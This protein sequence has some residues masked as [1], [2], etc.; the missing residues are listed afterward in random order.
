M[1]KGVIAFLGLIAALTVIVP[2]W[3]AAP[4]DEVPITC[5]VVDTEVAARLLGAPLGPP[6][7][8]NI[9]VCTG[10]CPSL[11]S[12]PRCSFPVA[13][14]TG[15]GQAKAL[16]VGLDLRPFEP[17]DWAA[18]SYMVGK[19]K[20]SSDVRYIRWDGH[21]TVWDFD[22]QENWAVY[23]VFVGPRRHLCATLQI[24]LD[25]IRDDAVALRTAQTLAQ[26]ALVR[27]SQATPEEMILPDWVKRPEIDRQALCVN[28]IG[29]G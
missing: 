20:P 12:E 10:L 4:E 25:G 8:E 1:P 24:M 7:F 16:Y 2:A 15:S 21:L 27:L 23:E 5:K 3:A 18:I 11:N 13:N 14:P 29:A 26:R 28:K 9:V 19:E 6:Q 17:G 22:P